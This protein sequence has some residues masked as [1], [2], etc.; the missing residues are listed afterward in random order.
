MPEKQVQVLGSVGRGFFLRKILP[1]N[2]PPYVIRPAVH[3]HQSL[4]HIQT[5]HIESSHVDLSLR[6]CIGFAAY[7]KAPD[8]LSHASLRRAP[9]ICM[10]NPC[11]RPIWKMSDFIH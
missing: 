8:L 7:A 3:V 4:K 1:Q 11:A 6:S 10:K 2:R 9:N 5:D